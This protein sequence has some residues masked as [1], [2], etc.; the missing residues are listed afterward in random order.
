MNETRTESVYEATHR[1][2]AR[3]GAPW[4]NEEFHTLIKGIIGGLSLTELADHHQRTCAGISWAAMRLIPPALRPDSHTQSVDV[5]ARYLREAEEVDQRSIVAAVC[6]AVG[7]PVHDVQV[8]DSANPPPP[9]GQSVLSN[10]TVSK[11]D[12]DTQAGDLR[13]IFAA[14]A[15]PSV[16]NA[17]G[18]DVVML[19]SAAVTGISGERDRNVLE[20]RLGMEEPL[21]LAEIGAEW[22][23]SGERVRQ[24]QERGFRRLAA[25]ARIE[26][27]PGATLKKLLEPIS[28]SPDDLVEW[29]F[30]IV[31]RDFMISQGLAARFILCTAGFP[32][33]QVLEIVALL[34]RLERSQKMRL[35]ELDQSSVAV[36]RI[37]SVLNDWLRYSDWPLVIEP[38]PP[39]I[40]LSAQRVVNDSDIAGGFYSHKLG[41]TVQFESGLELDILTLLERSERVAYYQEQPAVIPYTYNGKELQYYPDLFVSTVDGRGLL[42]E[43]KP[44]DC[45]ALSLNRAKAVAGRAWAH[46]RG[47]GW[48]IV[49]DHH[50]FRQLEEH[51]VPA[52]I[53][54]LIDS[55]LNA[56]GVLTWRDLVTLRTQHGLTRLD[57]TAYIIQ[58]GAELDRAY[59]ITSRKVSGFL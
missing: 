45:M 19:V 21:T 42:V 20:K 11:T 38:P 56:R 24:I 49:N 26:G 43:V 1:I 12:D 6:P 57:L 31:R 48:L 28:A 53:W 58:S 30:N 23:I 37:E 27:T 7:T 16:Y 34:P 54:T 2:P 29:L 55:E 8:R 51:H 17:I 9:A 4:E 44:T 50:T 59:R 14:N 10:A 32:K 33:R 15:E 18:S 13:E 36:E 41:R 5:L 22:D 40:Q 46:A 39:A 35:C 52:S 25:R 47:W 3:H